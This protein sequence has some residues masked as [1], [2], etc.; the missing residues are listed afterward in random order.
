M[1]E[2]LVYPYYFSVAIAERACSQRRVEAEEMLCGLLEGYAV[3]F[4]PVREPYRPG[5]FLIGHGKV[6]FTSS[7]QESRLYRIGGTAQFLRRVTGSKPVDDKFSAAHFRHQL[8]RSCIVKSDDTLF[9]VDTG[10]PLPDKE[11]D[12]FSRINIIRHCNGSSKHHPCSGVR[13]AR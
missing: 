5:C 3:F 4:E 7:R 2:A 10:I 12:V 1:T 11:F 9:G 6:Y 8:C 13:A